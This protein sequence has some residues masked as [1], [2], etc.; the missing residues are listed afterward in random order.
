MPARCTCPVAHRDHT[1]HHHPHLQTFVKV[2][3]SESIPNHH[4]TRIRSTLP[5]FRSG[6][7]GALCGPQFAL[8]YFFA[9]SAFIRRK[10]RC[11]HV[12]IYIY[13][14][15]YVAAQRQVTKRPESESAPAVSHPGI[16]HM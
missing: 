11:A 12:Y 8:T 1:G 6:G 13:I 9:W 10:R 7:G 3:L 16:I 4:I 15:I 5:Y 2:K 14:Y